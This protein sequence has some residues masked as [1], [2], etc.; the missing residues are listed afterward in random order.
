MASTNMEKSV[1]QVGPAWRLCPAPTLLRYLVEGHALPEHLTCSG[2]GRGGSKGEQRGAAVNQAAGRTTAGLS[3][4]PTAG[5]SPL[6]HLHPADTR[7]GKVRPRRYPEH[8]TATGWGLEHA[9]WGPRGGGLSL[10]PPAAAPSGPP[11]ARLGSPRCLRPLSSL[12]ALKSLPGASSPCQHGSVHARSKDSDDCKVFASIPPL[13]SP[14]PCRLPCLPGLPL[15]P[16]HQ[17]PPHGPSG[18]GWGMLLGRGRQEKALDRVLLLQIKVEAPGGCVM[19]QEQPY[20][21][22]GLRPRPCPGPEPLCATLGGPVYYRGG[23][24]WKNMPPWVGLRLLPCL[25]DAGSSF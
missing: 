5:S 16:A 2:Q 3:P 24:G 14:L 18:R 11:G 12:S 4:V 22:E 8:G 13:P 1:G 23:S 10:R 6:P 19:S 25:P 20:G 9:A 7:A 21:S 15:Q 17:Q